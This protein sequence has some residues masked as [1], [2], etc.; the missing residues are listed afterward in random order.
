MCELVVRFKG[1]GLADGHVISFPITQA[2]IGDALGL[3]NIHVN[4]SIRVLRLQGLISLKDRILEVF[5]WGGLQAA[6]N[7]DPA[8]L[9]LG[10]EKHD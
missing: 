7:F 10:N 3:T 2:E 6:A 1:V 9:Y 5:D 8:Y 4:R